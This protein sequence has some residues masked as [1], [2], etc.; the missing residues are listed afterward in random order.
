MGFGRGLLKDPRRLKQS[1]GGDVRPF[2]GVILLGR[3]AAVVIT[4]EGTPPFPP[5]PP[6]ITASLPSRGVFSLPFASARRPDE[7]WLF[8]HESRPFGIVPPGVRNFDI[9]VVNGVIARVNERGPHCVNENFVTERT[10]ISD[11]RD[12]L[13]QTLYERTAIR[14]RVTGEI[15]HEYSPILPC[16]VEGSPTGLQRTIFSPPGYIHVGR[17][18][19]AEQLL[20]ERP[21]QAMIAAQNRDQ[22]WA[23]DY[24]QDGLDGLDADGFVIVVM[25]NTAERH[26]ILAGATERATYYAV[27]TFLHEHA[28]T[29][30]LFPG[31]LGTVIPRNREFILGEAFFQVEEPHYRGRS[32]AAMVDGSLDQ[33]LIERATGNG[34]VSPS[35]VSGSTPEELNDMRNWLLRN[36]L[37]PSRERAALFYRRRDV[38]VD[39]TEH[40]VWANCQSLPLSKQRFLRDESRFPT[41]HNLSHFFS[42]NNGT[43]DPLVPA[44]MGQA[45]TRVAFLRD[46]FP[47]PARKVDP[48]LTEVVRAGDQLADRG[49]A[50]SCV[51]PVSV[52][53]RETATQQ[54]QDQCPNIEEIP[55]VPGTPTIPAPTMVRLLEGNSVGGVCSTVLA[56]RF[57]QC[58]SSAFSGQETPSTLRFIPR[59]FA[60]THAQVSRPVN[61]QWAPCLYE[62]RATPAGQ[63]SPF[64]Q[65]VARDL[66][67][68][69]VCSLGVCRMRSSPEDFQGEFCESIAFNDGLEVFM[70]E[71]VACRRSNGVDGYNGQAMIHKGQVIVA[72]R[73]LMWGAEPQRVYNL[74][75]G[76]ADEMRAWSRRQSGIVLD[77]ARRLGLE[78]ITLMETVTPDEIPRRLD[79]FALQGLIDDRARPNMHTRRVLDLVNHTA[80]F[81]EEELQRTDLLSRVQ[82]TF[83]TY[84]TYHAPPVFE[85]S[86]ATSPGSFYALDG[87][88][89]TGER[90][91]TVLHPALTPMITASRDV[92]EYGNAVTSRLDAPAKT[93]RFFERLRIAPEQ[94]NHHRWSLIAQQTGIYEYMQ[95]A[96]LTG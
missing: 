93:E 16:E 60:R 90:D 45:P 61:D 26:L 14:D 18:R 24:A 50:V 87:T 12:L 53:C 42:P 40:P 62:T 32:L 48:L 44:Q 94:S 29:R 20:R 71:C 4:P 7:P 17:T 76:S 37:H 51:R 52:M 84:A 70:C 19:R 91:E 41:E 74:I 9:E 72:D 75:A 25:A 67:E 82:L 63:L 88:P 58:F 35:S 96:C 8:P 5:L 28:G 3:P 77:P 92:A 69:L 13:V 78:G 65:T 81:M 47:N 1:F 89:P 21:I 23:W 79:R 54:C 59:T 46:M 83:H 73:T 85:K 6:E 95:G 43:M 10:M 49:Q 86:P 57:Q 66:A 68:Q 36:R 38:P 2:G 30:W 34:M 80:R 55:G 15:L 33:T 64:R 39:C 22:D 56:E 11:A 27:A 31:T